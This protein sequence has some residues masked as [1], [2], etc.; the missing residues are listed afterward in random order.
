MA[1]STSPVNWLRNT[2][3]LNKFVLGYLGCSIETARA[4]LGGSEFLPSEKS[5]DWL[6]PGIYF[7]E[8]DPLRAYRW[9][10]HPR[11]KVQNPTLVGAVLELGRCLD[12][13]TQNGIEAVLVGPKPGSG[14]SLHRCDSAG[15]LSP[16]NISPEKSYPDANCNR[17]VGECRQSA[18]QCFSSAGYCCKSDA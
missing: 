9:A 1:T 14:P 4:L 13:T 6:G 18:A 12:L 3:S 5:Y 2:E 16:R 8:D 11:R 10:C 15:T 17:S 7:W